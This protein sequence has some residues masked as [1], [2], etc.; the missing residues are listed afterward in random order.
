MKKDRARWLDPDVTVSICVAMYK[1]KGWLPFAGRRPPQPIVDC[2]AETAVRHWRDG[3]ARLGRTVGLVE[4]VE[5]SCR[6]FG[7]IA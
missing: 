4:Q 5:E 6:S 1:R 2:G 3:D 7:E